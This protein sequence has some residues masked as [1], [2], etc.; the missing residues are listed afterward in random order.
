MDIPGV[1]AVRDIVVNP[2]FAN[3]SLDDKWVVPVPPGRK[4]LLER[5]DSRLVFYKRNMPVTANKAKAAAR[6]AELERTTTTLMENTLREDLK[7]P[8]GSDRNPAAYYS[9]QNHFPALYGLSEDGLGSAAPE[10]RKALA[11]QL[12]GYLLF[13]D[14]MMANYLAQLSQVKELL[15]A[16]ANVKGSYFTQV[17]DTFVEFDKI[18]YQANPTAG[19]KGIVEDADTFVERRNRFLDH[20]IARFAEQFTDLAHIAYSALGTTPKQMIG[21]KCEFLADY[22]ERSSER[23]LA[24]DYTQVVPAKLWDTDNVSGLEKRLAKLLGLGPATRQNLSTGTGGMY[25]IEM[26]LLRPELNADPF[27]PICPDPNCTDCAD[28]DP[29]SYRI[30]VILPAEQ[31]RFAKIEFRRYVEEVIRQETPAHILPRIC[32][33]SNEEMAA[34]EVAYKDWIY[35]KAGADTTKRTAKLKAFIDIL[36]K[37]RNVYPAQKLHECDAPEGEQKFLLGQTALGTMKK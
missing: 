35:L 6:Y 7:V 27:A 37:V 28:E 32:W 34:L 8:L 18:Y 26:I 2:E 24:Y 25:V 10:E 23:A 29:Y 22:P 31:K 12:K 11:R 19:L 30:H 36:F 13:F 3:T 14:Q 1:R 15:S 21:I 16:D 5:E 33:I 4:A 20:L 9:F 17:V